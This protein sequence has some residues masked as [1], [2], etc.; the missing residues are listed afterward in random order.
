MSASSSKGSNTL[1][2]S[3]AR[4]VK[5]GQSSTSSLTLLKKLFHTLLGTGKVSILP[6]RNDSK[7]SA[8]KTTN[9]VNEL[10][11]VGARTFLKASRSNSTSIAGDLHILSSLSFQELCLHP[12]VSDWMNLNGYYLVLSDCQTSDMV[13]IGFLSRVCQ[14]TWRN[15]L[16]LMIKDTLEWPENPF[17]FRLYFGSISCNKKGTMAQV[18]MVE[19][20][21]DNIAAGMD[22]FCNMFDGE[23]PLSPCG[24]PY[25]FLTL[26]QNSLSDNERAKIIE[27]INHHVGDVQLIRLYGLK[28]IDG[29]VT[30]KQNVK[31]QLRK[32]LLNLR[33]PQTST[34][35]FNQVEKETDLESILCSF[36]SVMY[37]T[38]MG[39]LQ[40]ISLFIQQCAQEIDLP[41]IFVN[42]DY[43]ILVPPK[44]IS[45]KKGFFTSK[46]IPLEIQEH[47][48]FALS[49]MS[50]VENA[51]FLLILPHHLPFRH[52]VP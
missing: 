48:S 20:E 8:I 11:L 10:S 39:N 4:R 12:K 13:R 38:V 6:I 50:K 37:D 23:N 5:A 29:Y 3:L 34:R 32:L 46:T 33:A 2:I 28:N 7:V 49:K 41:S 25:L 36:D 19:V 1:R 51:N 30:L 40:N 44:A 21:R 14:F 31:V 22:F 52:L 35:L 18:L 27:D 9:Q 17:Q 24:I 45:P 16:R 47:T 43:S 15:D 42:Q 26:Y